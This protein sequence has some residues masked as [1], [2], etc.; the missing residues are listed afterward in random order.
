MGCMLYV[1]V[2]V[3]GKSV[4]HF[5]VAVCVRRWVFLFF[6]KAVGASCSSRIFMLFKELFFFSWSRKTTVFFQHYYLQYKL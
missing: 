2:S 3:F 4:R 1:C 5:F 6:D